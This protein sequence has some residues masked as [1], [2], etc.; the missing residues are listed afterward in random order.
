MDYIIRSAT[1]ED[2]A[3]LLAVYGEYIGT[4]ITFEEILPGVEEFRE[5][6]RKTLPYF[7]YLVACPAADAASL[8]ASGTVL[9]ASGTV[10]RTD[11]AGMTD[12]V[13][14]RAEAGIA[15][16]APIAYAYAGPFAKR[17][18][19]R[20]DA[21]LSIYIARAHTGRGL[22]RKLYAELL[23]LLAAQGYQNA[24]GI[25]TA[26]NPASDR[27]HAAFGFHQ[28]GVMRRTGYKNG[29]WHDVIYYEKEIGEHGVPPAEVSRA[30]DSDL[31]ESV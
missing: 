16:G 23:R 20:W 4:P 18:A 31:Q 14:P 22:G 27:L 21:E 7:P 5:R 15:C 8:R 24:Y 26:G 29:Q 10:L 12:A 11:D 17:A 19:Y 6:I 1:P 9:R 28:A 25:V 13:F 2:A 30:G 3:A